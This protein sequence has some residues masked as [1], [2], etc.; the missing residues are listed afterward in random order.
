MKK[1]VKSGKNAPEKTS[2]P[3][4]NDCI[5]T[6]EDYNN[7]LKERLEGETGTKLIKYE[8]LINIAPEYAFWL[9]KIVRYGNVDSQVL[10]FYSP[11]NKGGIEFKCKFYTN[12]HCYSIYGYKPTDDKND[13]HLGCIATMRK[14]RPGE[15][16]HH[17]N[18]LPHGNY[19]KKTFDEIV[20][21]IVA[22]ELKSLQLWRK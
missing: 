10:I 9:K 8:G 3:I 18:D 11:N 5:Q 20:R 12:D 19:S 1:N 17:G 15:D 22:Y 2:K 13:G 6:P 14:S 21:G 16:W 7:D 4:E